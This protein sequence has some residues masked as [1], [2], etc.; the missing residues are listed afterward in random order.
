MVSQQKDLSFSYCKIFT[1]TKDDPHAIKNPQWAPFEDI[2]Q[3]GAFGD[4]SENE[5]YLLIL[6][7]VPRIV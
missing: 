1:Q 3:L 5:D 7:A 6:F 2:P 4:I